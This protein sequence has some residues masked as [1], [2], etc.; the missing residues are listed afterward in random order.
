VCK[1][2]AQ[3]GADCDL[4][5][6]NGQTPIYYAA[7]GRKYD[8]VQFLIQNGSDVNHED[9]KFQTPLMIAKRTNAQQIVNLLIAHGAKAIDDLRK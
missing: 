8:T 5:D 9:K 4:V 1:K 3:C 6:N 2:L 7:R